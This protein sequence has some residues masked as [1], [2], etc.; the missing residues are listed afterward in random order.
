[1]VTVYLICVVAYVHTFEC[2]QYQSLTRC[3]ERGPA[4]AS[5]LT[6]AWNVRVRWRCR[7]N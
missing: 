3:V 6:A 2:G 7:S 1:M 5:H 4:I